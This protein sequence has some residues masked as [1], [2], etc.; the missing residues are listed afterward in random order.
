MVCYNNLLFPQQWGCL[1]SPPP[2][3]GTAA[4]G[5]KLSSSCSAKW[6][7]KALWCF[8]SDSHNHKN[9]IMTHYKATEFKRQRIMMRVSYCYTW[10]RSRWQLSCGE[11]GN[12]GVLGLLRALQLIHSPSHVCCQSMEPQGSVPAKKRKPSPLTIPW[13][14]NIIPNAKGVRTVLNICVTDSASSGKH[15]S[16]VRTT[17]TVKCI[18]L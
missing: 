9:R 6:L 12:K 15:R 5:S 14:M 7:P 16:I 2:L 13:I 11:K 4:L 1:S 10:L 3:Q 18:E 17:W 8:F